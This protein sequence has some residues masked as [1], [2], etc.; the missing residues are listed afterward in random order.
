LPLFFA[1]RACIWL[2]GAIFS[3]L[4]IAGDGCWHATNRHALARE[5]W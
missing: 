4:G 1:L 3:S 5:L 2:R